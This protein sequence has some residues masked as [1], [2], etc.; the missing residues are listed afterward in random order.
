M[1]TVQRGVKATP[2]QVF[3]VLADGWLYACW[4]VGT[5]RMRSVDQRWPAVGARLHHSVGAWPVVINDQTKMLR[6]EPNSRLTLEARFGLLGTALVDLQVTPTAAGAELSITEDI[7]R[8]LGRFPPKIIR[9]VLLG[10][11]NVEA[12]RRLALLVEGRHPDE[13]AQPV[14]DSPPSG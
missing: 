9:D 14:S 3:A 7:E 11:R 1:A 12:L 10:T 13:P 5:S 6:W 2:E 8:G 4:V